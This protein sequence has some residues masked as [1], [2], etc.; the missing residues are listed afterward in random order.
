MK[1]ILYLIFIFCSFIIFGQKKYST[2]EILKIFPFSKA[3]KVKM[4]SYN[5]DF[6]SE[7]PIPLP[8]IGHGIDSATIKKMMA[9]QKFPIK[10]ENILGKENL[11]GID[12]SKTLNFKEIFELSKLLY[13]TC[14]KFSSDLR[15]ANK[16]FFPR[17]AI[18]FYDENDKIFEILEICFE[19]Q[20]IRFTSENSLEI[21][22][23]CLNFYSQLEKLFKD[24][25]FQTQP[26]RN[27]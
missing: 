20:R 10:L 22:E 16:C 1:K 13:N 5:K 14:G 11:N 3:T 12:Q 18:L 17:N 7:F 2:N 23:M 15:E 21:N 27:Y 19:C 25:G 4:I 24:N 8:P 9:E 6:L 26:I